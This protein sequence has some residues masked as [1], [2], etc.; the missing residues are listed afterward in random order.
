MY[1]NDHEHEPREQTCI[2]Q[3]QQSRHYDFRNIHRLFLP[4]RVHDKDKLK[5]SDEVM[6]GRERRVISLLEGLPTARLVARLGS[7]ADCCQL[8]V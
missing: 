8:A 4:R 1:R 7:W 6:I 5:M 2:K 3:K